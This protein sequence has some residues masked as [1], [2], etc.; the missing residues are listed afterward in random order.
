MDGIPCAEL[1]RLQVCS[2]GCHIPTINSRKKKQVSTV[3][4]MRIFVVLDGAMVR[5]GF[6]R[7]IGQI[8]WE[9]VAEYVPDSIES[10]VLMIML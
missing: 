1:E 7:A 5:V 6:P 8:Y 10:C 9:K 4:R 3:R 2:S